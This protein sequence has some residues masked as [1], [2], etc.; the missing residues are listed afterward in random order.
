MSEVKTWV[1]RSQVDG[2]EVMIP[3]GRDS[4]DTSAE[5]RLAF[6]VKNPKSFKLTEVLPVWPSSLYSRDSGGTEQ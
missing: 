4:L 2:T 5:E 3:L 6:F 1:F